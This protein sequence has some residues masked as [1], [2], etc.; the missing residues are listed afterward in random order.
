MAAKS[1]D[2]GFDNAVF[3]YKNNK[4]GRIFYVMLTLWCFWAYNVNMNL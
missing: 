3:L 4:F 1:R 2:F